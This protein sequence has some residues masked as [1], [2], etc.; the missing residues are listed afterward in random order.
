MKDVFYH[1]HTKR[2]AGEHAPRTM[3]VDYKIGWRQFRSEWVCFEHDGFAR[4]KAEAWWR[5]RS[6]DPVPATAQR[7]VD[8]ANNGGVALT[9]AIV[10][11]SIAGEPH[12]RIIDYE[13][14]PLPEA[15][16]VVIT[17]GPSKAL[18]MASA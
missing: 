3:R 11:R 18:K 6:P 14:G 4:L 8:V 1:V 7:A 13:L 17:V 12:D 9:T 10:V 2:G 15:V 5:L 16:P